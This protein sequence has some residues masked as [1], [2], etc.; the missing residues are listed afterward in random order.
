M[1][2]THDGFADDLEFQLPNNERDL[3]VT[4]VDTEKGTI[5]TDDD[6]RTS[7]P[8]GG[9]F[10]VGDA[11][12]GNLGYLVGRNVILGSNA[13]RELMNF[14]VEDQSV[15]IAK[16]KYVEKDAGDADKNYFETPDETKYYLTD[17]ATTT[18]A[19]TQMYDAADGTAIFGL[20]DKD[21]FQYAKLVLNKNGTVATAMLQ[22]ATAWDGHIIATSIDDTKVEESADFALDFDGYTIVKDDEYVEVSDLEEGDILYYNTGDKFVDVYTEAVT[23]N[24]EKITSEKITIDGTA[25][26]W[27]GAQY[28]KND[29][30]NTL[31]GEDATVEADLKY[32]YS[33]DEDADTTIVLNRKGDVQVI[34]GTVKDESKTTSSIYVMTDKGEVYSIGKTNYLELEGSNGTQETLKIDLS[35]LKKYDNKDVKTVAI[36]PKTTLT[37]NG[38]ADNTATKFAAGEPVKITKNEDGTVVEIDTRETVAKPGSTKLSDNKTTQTI[39]SDST[40][41]LSTVANTKITLKS[42]TPVYIV[43]DKADDDGVAPFKV[44]K[45]TIGELTKTALGDKVTAYV[46]T[47]S[48]TAE[49]VLIDNTNGDAWTTSDTETIG[50][51]V[52]EITEGLNTSSGKEEIESIKLLTATGEVELDADELGFTTA[53]KLGDYNGFTVKKG[54]YTLASDKTTA[55]KFE[56]AITLDPS[57]AYSDTKFTDMNGA[58]TVSKA[59]QSKVF[60]YNA[61]E[62]TY[63]ETTIGAVN[64]KKEEATLKYHIVD[65]NTPGVVSSDVM[66]VQYAGK[67][68]TGDLT[69]DAAAFAQNT[70]ATTQIGTGT[71]ETPAGATMAY[72]LQY[73]DGAN[74][75]NTGMPTVTNTSGKLTVAAGATWTANRSYRLHNKTT[76]YTAEVSNVVT[77]AKQKLTAIT[78][79]TDTAVPSTSNSGTQALTPLDQ[80]GANFTAGGT[81]TVK[82]TKDAD[83]GATT[84]GTVANTGGNLTAT[85][86]AAGTLTMKADAALALSQTWELTLDDVKLYARCT[87]STN[88]NAWTVTLDNTDYC[89]Y[90]PVATGVS[91]EAAAA[92]A[93]SDGTA[94]QGT[95][96]LTDQHGTVIATPNAAYQVAATTMSAVGTPTGDHTMKIASSTS[97]VI[98]LTGTA[99]TTDYVAGDEVTADITIAGVTYVATAT[100]AVTGGPTAA[101]WTTAIV[102]K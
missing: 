90:I 21:E 72:E 24:I 49:Y 44:E 79:A 37:I 42:S 7:N 67:V 27:P 48:T 98:T 11:Y 8:G 26:K 54:T 89:A 25:Y 32:L 35:K 46:K 19:A 61:T 6:G 87:A 91:F 52:A 22:G 70:T 12:L 51:I 41:L 34:D 63:T 40:S 43:N 80:F 47:T 56:T 14:T 96:T 100:C 83:T 97:G 92:A 65:E 53:L 38:T 64:T 15:V 31:S 86:D 99:G 10:T 73:W 59:A 45:T 75:V 78:L 85:L 39:N 3:I 28:W 62:K 50:G 71:A 57:R 1:T 94:S 60:V 74:W 93:V 77:T 33:L 9:L 5:F 102:K 69:L 101:T 23:G 20:T 88:Q 58:V 30:Y 4:S 81:F 55:D 66:V 95:I 16:V 76:D 29:K 82:N 13:D 84:A 2:V 17:D 18:V 68:Q 36:T